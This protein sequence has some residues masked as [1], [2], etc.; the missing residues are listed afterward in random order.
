MRQRAG[1]AAAEAAAS[2]CRT[3][4]AGKAPAKSSCDKHKGADPDKC[5]SDRE[6]E[7]VVKEYV[8]QLRRAYP[9]MVLEPYMMSVGALAAAD[10]GSVATETAT[11]DQFGCAPPRRTPLCVCTAAF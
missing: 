1:A 8:R 5:P 2:F 3:I 6:A 4:L 7:A 10:C 11:P 9:G